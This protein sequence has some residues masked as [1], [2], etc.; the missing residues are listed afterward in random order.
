MS[1]LA[2][3]ILFFLLVFSA[4]ACSTVEPLLLQDPS[5][6]VAWP[7]PPNPPRIK[8]LREI[9]GPDQ[10]YPLKGRMQEFSDFMLGDTRAVIDFQT[11]YAITTNN[12]DI[13]YIADTTAG[14]VHRYDLKNRE[15]SYILKAGDQTLSSPA[16]VALDSDEN[17]Y[18]SDSVLA[19]VYK[20]N[21]DGDYLKELVLPSGFKRPAGIAINGS[22]DKFVVDS[23]AHKVQKFDSADNYAGEFLKEQPGEELNTPTHVAVDGKG[24]LYLTDAMNFVIRVYDS[25]GKFVRRIGEI[26]DVPGTFARPKGI[27]VDSRRNIY[28]VD[29]NH[30]NFQIFN[31]DGR[32]LLFVGSNGSAPGEFILPS[33]IHIDANDRIFIADTFNR[34]IQVFQL[35]KAGGTND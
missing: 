13:L 10:I 9:D 1:R 7:A 31:Q 26:G 34:R 28:V 4:A 19:R 3:Y 29:A 11:P 14:V 20:F 33:G 23:V 8:Y 32:L 5:V 16:A 17:L 21:G 22:G 24:Y 25:N 15:V 18:I 2:R 30:D 27:A 12:R 6:N 35:L